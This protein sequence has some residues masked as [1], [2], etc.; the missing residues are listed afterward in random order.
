MKEKL[1]NLSYALAAIIPG[2]V[3]F[4]AGYLKLMSPAEEF[5]F[6][7]EAYKVVSGKT[8]LFAA[9]FF[10][11]FELYLGAFLILGIFRKQ[12]CLS[13]IG[14]F[15]FFE[16]FLGQAAL[17]GLELKDCGCFGAAHSNSLPVEMLLNLIWLALLFAAYKKSSSFS[18]DAFFERKFKNEK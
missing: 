1:S 7:I 3:L 16:L 14:V 4:Y 8:A 13:A 5:A 12:A 18:L 6:S 10:P 2:A 17:R 15:I 9:T 11:W